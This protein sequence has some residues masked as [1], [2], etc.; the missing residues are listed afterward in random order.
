MLCDQQHYTN[1]EECVCSAEVKGGN[2]CIEMVYHNSKHEI[3][4]YRVVFYSAV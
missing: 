4:A 3:I 2:D 1:D